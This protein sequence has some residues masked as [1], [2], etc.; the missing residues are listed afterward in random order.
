MSML[1]HSIY[2]WLK[3]ELTP[4]QLADFDAGLQSLTAIETVKGLHFGKPTPSDRPVVECSYTRGLVVHFDDQPGLDT[5]AVHPV[6]LAFVEEFKPFWTD[7]K[8]FDV[9]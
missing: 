9:E 6:H 3:P 8:V 1:V 7:I 2:F 5:Y 4:E